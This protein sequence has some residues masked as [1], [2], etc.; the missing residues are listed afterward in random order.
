MFAPALPIPL[1][2]GCCVPFLRRLHSTIGRGFPL[3]KQVKLNELSSLT[4]ILSFHSE[5]SVGAA[6]L[7][8][9]KSS[10]YN[11]SIIEFKL[12]G[13]IFKIPL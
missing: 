4:A 12:S 8:K 7:I 3:A 1:L 13:A 10:V 9:K 2:I 5:I 6:K 11:L